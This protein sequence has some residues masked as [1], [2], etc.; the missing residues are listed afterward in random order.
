MSESDSHL[1][2]NRIRRLRTARGWQ[3]AELARRSGLTHDRLDAIE[4]GAPPSRPERVGLARALGVS[5]TW[6]WPG[7]RMLGLPWTPLTKVL[8]YLVVIALAS[9]VV[10]ACNAGVALAMADSRAGYCVL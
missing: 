3:V 8:T 5:R 2:A 7:P 6:L 1:V 4:T 10:S 9:G